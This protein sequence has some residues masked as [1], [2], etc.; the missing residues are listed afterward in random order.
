MLGEDLELANENAIIL[1]RYDGDFSTSDLLSEKDKSV[2]TDIYNGTK[3]RVRS[4]QARTAQNPKLI[5]DLKSRLEIIDG[6][7]QDSLTDT[8][9][10]IEDFLIFANKEIGETRHLIDHTFLTASSM[11]SWNPQ[12]I[13]FIQQD[14]I[15][16][17]DNLLNSIYELFSDKSSAINKYNEYRAANDPN[18]IDLKHYAS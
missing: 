18:A 5:A 6:K 11:D 16:H 13:N 4:Q 12:E 10:I 2:L 17:Y 8:F 1:D 15:G 3:T 9:D 14:L 7:N